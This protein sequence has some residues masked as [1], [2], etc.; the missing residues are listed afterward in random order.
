MLEVLCILVREEPP[1]FRSFGGDGA[2]GTPVISIITVFFFA[3]TRWRTAITPGILIV[4][5]YGDV[6][7]RFS[8]PVAPLTFTR[9]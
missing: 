6:Y 3:V 7:L 9:S 8:S 4:I 1:P 2:E 5:V